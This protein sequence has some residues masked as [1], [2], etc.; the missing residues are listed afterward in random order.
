MSSFAIFGLSGDPLSN[1]TLNVL[2]EYQVDITDDDA[3]LEDPD[4]NGSAQFD[5]SPLP[6]AINSANLQ[7]FEE[8]TGT[9]GGQPVAF[10]L[11]RFSGQDLIVLTQGTLAPG[12][13][14]TGITLQTFNGSPITYTDLPTYICFDSDAMIATT[15][16]EVRVSA[17][18]EGDLVLTADDGPQPVR[19]VAQ[20]AFSAREMSVRP[21]LRPVVIPAHAFG[22]GAPDRPLTVSPQHRMLLRGM[23][24]SL[25]FG[26]PEV[27]A[28]AKSLL[29]TLARP[30][31]PDRGAHYHHILFEKHQVIW[32]NG[33][34]TES[35][36]PGKEATSTLEQDFR[37]ELAEIFPD[38]ALSGDAAPSRLCLKHFE[39]RAL[40]RAQT[41]FRAG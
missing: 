23:E 3:S 28:T 36:L 5:T 4:Q 17:L 35:L 7:V 31:A 11:I 27:F 29:G 39:G 21:H 33:A 14:I 16:G 37:G 26:A 24:A 2:A 18:R 12:N 15:K 1:A 40:A 32:A 34:R 38:L 20:R 13:T 30:A 41:D 6:G 19:L 8:Y 22:P 9:V 25:L 10:T